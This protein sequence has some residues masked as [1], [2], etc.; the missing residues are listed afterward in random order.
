MWPW[1][2]RIFGQ[3]ARIQHPVKG[4]WEIEQDDG[5]SLLMVRMVRNVWVEG[6]N[7]VDGEA[8]VSAP[9]FWVARIGKADEGCEDAFLGLHFK[10]VWLY[11]DTMLLAP[12]MD[13]DAVVFKTKNVVV[14]E[15]E[16]KEDKR[17]DH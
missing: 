12:F 10:E 13:K 11:W 4:M 5:E 6:G 15:K 8:D 2:Q 16:E 3:F 14:E 7:G 9:A 17:Q 1:M